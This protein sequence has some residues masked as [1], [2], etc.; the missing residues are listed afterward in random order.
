MDDV[1]TETIEQDFRQ[2]VCSKISLLEEGIDRYRVFTPFLSEDGDHFAIMLKREPSGWILSDEGHALMH[3]TYDKDEKDLRRGAR[4][5]I[6]NNALSLFHVKD[7]DG[8]IILSIPDHQFGDALNSYIHALMRI[9]DR[10]NC[11]KP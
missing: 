6:I 2:K 5:Q 10:E 1:T 11:I 8:E 3:L 4:Q 7:R 9:T